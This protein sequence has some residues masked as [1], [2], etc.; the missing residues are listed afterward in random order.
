MMLQD[1]CDHV[2]DFDPIRR[3]TVLRV[4]VFWN[5]LSCLQNVVFCQKIREIVRH[6]M[7]CGC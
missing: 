2:W 4:M 3:D 5:G 7:V 6:R 1:V